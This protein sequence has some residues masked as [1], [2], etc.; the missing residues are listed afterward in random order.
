MLIGNRRQG[1]DLINVGARRSEKWLK[2]HFIDPQTYV[3]GSSMPSYGH[4]FETDRGDDHG[5]YLK[6]HVLELGEG[7]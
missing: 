6:D 2:L 4:L 3:P 1:P 7:R 5:R